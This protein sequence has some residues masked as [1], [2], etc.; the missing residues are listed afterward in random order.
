LGEIFIKDG[1][2]VWA[3]DETKALNEKFNELTKKKEVKK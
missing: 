1:E 3:T 2:F